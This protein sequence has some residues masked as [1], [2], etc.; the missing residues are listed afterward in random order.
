[1]STPAHRSSPLGCT[2]LVVVSIALAGCATW[3]APVDTSDVPLRARAVTESKRDVQLSATVLGAD[4]SLRLF[5]TD[6]TAAGV[7]PVWIEVRNDTDQVF[8]LLRSGTDPDYFSPL[9]V[10]WS[11]H[12]KFRGATNARIDEHFERL[13][14]PNPIPPRGTSSGV[15]FTTRNWSTSC[16]CRP[17]RQQADIPFTCSCWLSGMRLKRGT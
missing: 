1:M 15:L 5:G 9:E 3:T 11:A 16:Q 10:A 12:F 14:F 2:W 7:Q 8:W 6:V 17:A 13:A 4:D